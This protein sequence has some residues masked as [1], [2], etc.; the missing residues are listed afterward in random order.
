MNHKKPAFSVK[1]LFLVALTFVLILT[2]SSCKTNV[3][4]H[5]V[6]QYGNELGASANK[7]TESADETPVDVQTA[8]QPVEPQGS[9]N[10]EPSENDNAN[11]YQVGQEVTIDDF[12]FTLTKVYYTQNV[13]FEHISTALEFATAKE[14]YTWLSYYVDITFHGKK[15]V[16]ARNAFLPSVQYGDN[17]DT[18]VTNYF[19]K[20]V[21][22]ENGMVYVPILRRPLIMVWTT[23]ILCM[24][25]ML[26]IPFPCTARLKS[27]LRWLK[28]K[29][30]LWCWNCISPPKW[31]PFL[32]LPAYPS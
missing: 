26:I 11:T 7:S 32:T 22:T 13:P 3:L 21:L 23:I 27:R 15:K 4:I 28:T 10:M 31:T 12:T 24:T 17:Y 25:R 20:N 18:F 9:G 1:S 2:C 8:V 29:H 30:L 14:G 16:L 19:M 5:L 6:D